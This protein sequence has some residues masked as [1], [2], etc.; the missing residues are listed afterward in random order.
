MPEF[1]V[2][3]SPSKVS[4]DLS[5]QSLRRPRQS[6]EG[7]PDIYSRALGGERATQWSLLIGHQQFC[8]T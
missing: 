2:A 3:G 8:V 5:G 4:L 6:R 1:G 7:D